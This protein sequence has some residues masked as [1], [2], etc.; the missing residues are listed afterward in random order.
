MWFSKPY[1]TNHCQVTFHTFGWSPVEPSQVFFDALI[2]MGK[3][4]C[5]RLLFVERHFEKFNLEDEI[6]FSVFVRKIPVFK[7]Y[8]KICSKKVSFIKH[9]DESKIDDY[10]R[11]S[12]R[13][14]EMTDYLWWIWYVSC[15][16]FILI[17]DYY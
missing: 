17:I 14:T 8:V 12:V 6:S 10:D 4:V 5:W 7:N 15:N 9:P 1:I 2:Y 13:Q 3:C 11:L 16:P